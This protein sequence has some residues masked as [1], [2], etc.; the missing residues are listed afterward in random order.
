MGAVYGQTA[1]QRR[2]RRTQRQRE[3][4]QEK[5]AA[6]ESAVQ[7]A[8]ER[9]PTPT[10]GLPSQTAGGVVRRPRSARAGRDTC[11]RKSP[12]TK[13]P[14]PQHRLPER[15]RLRVS[16]RFVC[17]PLE[18]QLRR[19]GTP[20][21]KQPVDEPAEL[22]VLVGR[23][24]D[25]VHPRVDRG[26]HVAPSRVAWPYA[27]SR[28]ASDSSRLAASLSSTLPSGSSRSTIPDGLR[29]A[30]KRHGSPQGTPRGAF[31]A[32]GSSWGSL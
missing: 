31:R 12:P 21:A 15:T 18:R 6:A 13:S 27:A 8:S 23:A 2:A 14:C 25:L 10:E 26:G 3:L 32:W 19:E 1:C 30:R 5:A 4:R 9:Q 29:N 7:A 17:E 20:H 11:L 28:C 22:L 16:Q 24:G